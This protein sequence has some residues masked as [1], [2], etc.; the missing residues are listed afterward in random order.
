MIKKSFIV[1]VALTMMLL[2]LAPVS[3]NENIGQSIQIDKKVKEIVVDQE[4]VAKCSDIS[5]MKKFNEK[6]L[7]CLA[8]DFTISE[9]VK[10]DGML[11]YTFKSKK[12]IEAI[13]YEDGTTDQVM[14]LSSVTVS[15]TDSDFYVVMYYRLDYQEITFGNIAYGKPT[16]AYSKVVTLMENGMRNLWIRTGVVGSY[17]DSNGPVG[18]IGTGIIR[19]A[20]AYSPIE[21]QLYYFDPSY[22]YYYCL[23]EIGGGGIGCGTSVEWTHNG[24]TYYTSSF[25][26]IR[27]GPFGF[28]LF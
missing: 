2:S 3:A 15:R 20:I 21:G 17:A 26:N 5:N 8:E 9:S 22:S 28:P 24:T 27:I 13:L 23:D 1:S 18:Y 4:M 6:I 14:S 7:D 12:P 10:T 25:E 19:S 16:R 11:E